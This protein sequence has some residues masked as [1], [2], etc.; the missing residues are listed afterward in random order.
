MKPTLLLLPGTLCDARIFRHQCRALRDVADLR[1]LDYAGLDRSGVWLDRLLG[2]L[3]EQ[4]SIA[5]FSLG[6]L[7]A[8]ELLRRAPQR[9]QPGPPVGV[10]AAAAPASGVS[11]SARVRRPWRAAPSRR[12]FTTRVSASAMGRWCGPWPMPRRVTWHALSSRG[13]PHARIVCRPCT[14]LAARCCSSAA[15]TT[16]CAL[17]LGSAKCSRPNRLRAGWNC[18][19]LGTLYRSKH[20]GA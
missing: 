17:P 14:A 2:E 16:A 18:P 10:P 20:P 11:G 15:N 13:L 3:P 12:T 4:F 7:W 1:A 9:V 19:A 8:L 6:G 5:G